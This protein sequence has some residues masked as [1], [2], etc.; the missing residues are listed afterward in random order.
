VVK[1]EDLGNL[2]LKGL[3]RPVAAFNV[4][5]SASAADARPNIDRRRERAGGLTRGL[6]ATQLSQFPS[7]PRRSLKGHQ[8]A[9]PRPRLSARCRFGQ[10]TFVGT[11]GNARDAPIRDPRA[12][13]G[14]SGSLE[15][16]HGR[17]TSDLRFWRVRLRPHPLWRARCLKTHAGLRRPLSAPNLARSLCRW[18]CH[19]EP[20]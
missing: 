9:F 4:V 15:R 18:N 20:G 12:R 6:K 8:D 2:A 17:L 10:E 3:S 1:L 14:T 7:R 19:A 13:S 16:S 11:R 5:H